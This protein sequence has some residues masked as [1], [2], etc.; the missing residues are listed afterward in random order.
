[1]LANKL[2]WYESGFLFTEVYTQFLLL[3]PLDIVAECIFK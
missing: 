3:N 1:M 2:H